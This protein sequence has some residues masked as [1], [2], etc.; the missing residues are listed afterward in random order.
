M[1]TFFLIFFSVFFSLQ[2]G[3]LP[4]EMIIKKEFYELQNKM[5]QNQESDSNKEEM[6]K[7]NNY[8]VSWQ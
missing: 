8:P 2:Y 3:R 4:P 1:K 7:C 5:T 6:N